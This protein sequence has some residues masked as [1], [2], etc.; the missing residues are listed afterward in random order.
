V[1]PAFRGQCL[2]HQQVERAFQTIVGVRAHLS[3]TSN[4]SSHSQL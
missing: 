3:P 1:H 2:Q 4:K